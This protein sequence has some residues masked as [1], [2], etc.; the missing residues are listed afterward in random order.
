MIGDANGDSIVDSTD[1]AIVRQHLFEQPVDTL[2]VATA[3]T[4]DDD[5]LDLSDLVGVVRQIYRNDHPGVTLPSPI[6]LPYGESDKKVDHSVRLAMCQS[7]D[8]VRF[9]AA[10]QQVVPITFTGAPASASAFQFDLLTTGMEVLDIALADSLKSSHSLF[11]A[12]L[13]GNALRVMVY[14]DSLQH[15]D[16]S[17]QVPAFLLTVRCSNQPDTINYRQAAIRFSNVR[18]MQS[19]M[20]P[21]YLEDAEVPFTWR[22]VPIPGDV[23]SNGIVDIDDLNLMV[24]IM[25]RK[26]PLADFPYSDANHSGLVDVDDVNLV[27]NSMLRRTSIMDVAVGDVHFKMVKLF[28]GTFTMGATPEQAEY[29]ADNEQPPHRVSVSDFAIGQTEVT[30]ELW[31]AVMGSNPSEFVGDPQLPVENVSW[32]DCQEF[33]ARLNELTGMQFRLPTEA[34]WEFAARGGNSSMGYVYSGSN[35]IKHVAWHNGNS[36]LQ[37][38]PVAQKRPNELGLYDMSGNV[39]EW[40]ADWYA[41]YSGPEDVTDPTGPETGTRRVCR[42]GC[43]WTL[44]NVCRVSYRT[45]FDPD[46][47]LNRFGLRLAL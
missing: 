18:V 40:C 9:V 28:G 35:S 4:Y 44:A 13:R 11:V 15:I 41:H 36:G 21:H 16:G 37:T 38:H 2:V 34:E 43:W 39:W 19:D 22:R 1:L 12:P 24:N 7:S 5:V 42:G 30:Q 45:K 46:T 32:D 25:M 20:F 29:A 17:G 14:S 31:E 47:R 3:N 23:D 26:S 27:I 6:T 10:D 8:T 33:I